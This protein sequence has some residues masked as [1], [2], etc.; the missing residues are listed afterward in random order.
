MPRVRVQAI[1]LECADG[2][3]TTAHARGECR[4]RPCPSALRPSA[5]SILWKLRG[6]GYTRDRVESEVYPGL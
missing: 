6:R 4:A 3:R 5:E 2:E 1:F